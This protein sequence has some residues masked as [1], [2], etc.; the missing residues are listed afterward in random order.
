MPSDEYT[1]VIFRQKIHYTLRSS[2]SRAV[3]VS[4]HI[5]FPL[6]TYKPRDDF[7][8]SGEHRNSPDLDSGLG[9]TEVAQPIARD[10]VVSGLEEEDH[11]TEVKMLDDIETIAGHT[12]DTIGSLSKLDHVGNGLERS[13][14]PSK[15]RSTIKRH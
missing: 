5:N 3:A 10:H 12:P 4:P 2:D 8:F 1:S 14:G 11:D 13:E 6:P 15:W 9:P 7:E